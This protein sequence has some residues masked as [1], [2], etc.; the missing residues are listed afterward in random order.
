MYLRYPTVGKGDRR[1]SL[2]NTRK[3]EEMGKKDEMV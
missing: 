2:L 3:E 1:I